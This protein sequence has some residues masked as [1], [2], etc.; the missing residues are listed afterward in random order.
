[1]KPPD[2]L[3]TRSR[4]S[5][6][7]LLTLAVLSPS[8][9]ANGG[10]DGGKFPLLSSSTH[11]PQP[12]REGLCREGPRGEGTST[13]GEGPPP[14]EPP[15]PS[16]EGP[17]PPR[18]GPLSPRRS[19]SLRE[20]PHTQPGRAPPGAGACARVTPRAAAAATR[21]WPGCWPSPPGAR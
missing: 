20:P 11:S 15:P 16:G 7:S 3:H 6:L 18:K 5:V 17:S 13:P 21:G 1:M 4:V 2:T 9:S 19:P 12:G 8:P 14:E 10:E